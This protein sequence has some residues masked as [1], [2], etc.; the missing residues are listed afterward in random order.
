LDP[1][2]RYFPSVWLPSDTPELIQELFKVCPK[3]KKQD[4]I[5]YLI[6]LAPTM[7][8]VNPILQKYTRESKKGDVVYLTLKYVSF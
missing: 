3:W 7:K 2:I 4:M 8:E 6:H 5:P 1:T